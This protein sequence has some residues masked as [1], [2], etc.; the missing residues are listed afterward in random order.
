[1]VDELGQAE[2]GDLG[3]VVVQPRR[4]SGARAL[5][6][7]WRVAAEREQD[8]GRLQVAVDDTALV[9][10]LHGASQR[11]D[12]GGGI[13]AGYGPRAFPQPASQRRPRTVGG[14]QEGYRPCLARFINRDNVGMLQAG[15]GLCLAAEALAPTRRD[16]DLGPR[17][18]QGHVAVQERVMS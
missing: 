16:E 3:D 17:H 7:R 11:G 15:G 6:L 9:R 2:V 1:G 5:A 4:A 12:E 18:F 14:Y 8:V 10:L 13:G